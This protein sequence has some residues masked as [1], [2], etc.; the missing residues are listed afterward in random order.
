ML[1]NT[2]IKRDRNEYDKLRMA[3]NIIFFFFIHK[4]NSDNLQDTKPADD[5]ATD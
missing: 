2:Q 4:N 5:L 3:V 1:K